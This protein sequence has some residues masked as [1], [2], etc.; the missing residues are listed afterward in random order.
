MKLTISQERIH[1]IE[2]IATY[3][4]KK[5]TSVESGQHDLIWFLEGPLFIDVNFYGVENYVYKINIGLVGKKREIYISDMLFVANLNY[6]CAVMIGHY[7]LHADEGKKH[8]KLT[9]YRMK[10]KELEAIY[11]AAFFLIPKKEIAHWRKHEYTADD[12]ETIF[13]VPEHLMKLRLRAYNDKKS[14]D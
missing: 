12:M 5:Y 4:R 14:N 7:F 10:E 9:S 8:F 2:E 6:M 3:A 13:N 1:E 11:F